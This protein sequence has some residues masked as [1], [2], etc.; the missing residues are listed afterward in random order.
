MKP[1]SMC[2]T[3]MLLLSF[4]F[5]LPAQS[6]QAGLAP[7]MP[8]ASAAAYYYIARPGELTMQ[9]NIWGAIRNA[10]RYEVPSST[11]LVQLISYAGGPGADA[12]LDEVRVVRS[13]K[14]GV[15][16]RT[17][18]VVNLDDLSNIDNSKLVLQPGDTITINHSNWSTV[19]DV[20]SVITTVAIVTTAIAYIIIAQE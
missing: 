5:S 14:E 12:V 1:Q 15:S 11:D 3:L 6:T 2:L 16:E 19:R 9:V 4:N 18:Y 17:T 13:A 8:S 20:M 7:V 10:G